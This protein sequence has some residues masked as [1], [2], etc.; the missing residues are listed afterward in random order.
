MGYQKLVRCI[1][2]C[3]NCSMRRKIWEIL[4]IKV[5]WQKQPRNPGQL[6]SGFLRN[7]RFVFRTGVYRDFPGMYGLREGMEGGFS[8]IPYR[9]RSLFILDM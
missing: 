9:R 7:I 2:V 5:F 4:L 3:W 1:N 8:F 6:W